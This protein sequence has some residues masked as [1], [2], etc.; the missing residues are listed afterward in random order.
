[1]LTAY[2]FHYFTQYSIV[3]LLFFLDFHKLIS[4]SL[5][6]LPALAYGYTM[7]KIII[8]YSFLLKLPSQIIVI[9]F[10]LEILI[11]AKLLWSSQQQRKKNAGG[12]KKV[13]ATFFIV[14]TFPFYLEYGVSGRKERVKNK[15]TKKSLPLVCLIFYSPKL[16]S[17]PSP[18]H[19]STYSF[20]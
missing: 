18:S 7:G 8:K 11:I 5:R 1:M 9:L 14:I 2:N 12:H 13:T 20:F 4:F 6:K 19:S 15:Q 17:L 10:S 3:V 16:L